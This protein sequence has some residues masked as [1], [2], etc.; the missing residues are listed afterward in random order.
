LS[1]PSLTDFEVFKASGT[2]VQWG[3]T[4]GYFRRFG[5]GTTA[6]AAAPRPQAVPSA[7]YVQTGKWEIDVH[8]GGLTGATPTK[9][10]GALPPAGDSF[11][12]LNNR[13]SRRVTSYYFGDGAALLNQ[14]NAALNVGSSL[15][16]PLDSVLQESGTSRNGSGTFGIRV[17]RHLTSRFSGEFSLDFGYG[18]LALSEDARAGIEASR[19]SFTRAWTALIGTGAGLFTNVNVTSTVDRRDEVGSQLM[20]TGAVNIN[21]TRPRAVV[22]YATIGIG[23]AS[24]RGETPRVT[25]TGNYRFQIGT[26]VPSIAPFDDTDTVDVR[27][28]NSGSD[29]VTLLG[30]GVKRDVSTRWGLRTDVRWFL[31]SNGTEVR[32]DATPNHRILTLPF[33]IPSNTTPSMQ[34]SNNTTTMATFSGAPITDFR[35]FT[36]TGRVV[37][38]QVTFGWYMRF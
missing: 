16:T 14:V 27:W 23:V 29:V 24:H 18:K 37:Q 35:T 11:N 4:F 7:P 21:L 38:T 30:L 34:F 26:A 17:T 2:S 1:G 6:A 15:I 3:A 32:I 31:G 5:G 20:A 9:G 25:L 36:G 33:A 8:G 13:P 12:T 28:V 10:A 22:P 19:E